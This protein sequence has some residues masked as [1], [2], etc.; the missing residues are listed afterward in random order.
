[1]PSANAPAG[2]GMPLQRLVGGACEW[3]N[4]RL[5]GRQVRFCS[6]AHRM[7]AWERDHPR[8]KPAQLSL[9]DPPRGIQF[10]GPGYEATKDQARLERHCARVLAVLSGAG[11]L[12]GGGWWDYETLAMAA[13]VPVG[14]VRTRVSNLKALGHH[15]EWRTRPDR[16]R[17]VRLV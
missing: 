16:F 5:T 4:D 17:E 2:Q 10:K 12:A 6:D 9:L 8:L 1:M 15:I 11:V 13:Q 7:K 14:S 3:C